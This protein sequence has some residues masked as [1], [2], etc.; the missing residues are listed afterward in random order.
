[1]SKRSVIVSKAFT[2]VE[3]LVVIVV[4]GI[5]AAIGIVAYN[6]IQNR[7][8]IDV[9][10][11]ELAQNYKQLATYAIVNSD[12]YPGTILAAQAAGVKNA[13]GTTIAYIP[14][15][16]TVPAATPQTFCLQETYGPS[17]Y[18]VSSVTSSAAAAG[19]CGSS[20]CPSGYIPVPGNS[21]FGTSDF[22]IMKYDAKNVSGIVV[23]QPSGVLWE[24][25]TQTNAISLAASSCA[26]CHIPTES[27]W[28]T[29]A[30]NVLSVST[31]WSGGSVG[32]GYIYS[33]HS[34]NNPNTDGLGSDT[35]DAN[36]YFGESSPTLDQK[37]TLTL[38]NGAVIWDFAGN[39]WQWTQGTV[40]GNQQPGL[41]GDAG[42]TV[43][44]WTDGSLVIRG[45]P[46]LS[47]PGSVSSQAGTWNSTQGVGKIDSYYGE[48]LLHGIT[49]GGSRNNTART[50][51][52]SVELAGDT[53]TSNWS[54]LGVRIVAAP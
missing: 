22:C 2:I 27:E 50:G 34:D 7:V 4:I 9:I 51:V 52:L 44:E 16:S 33:G 13:T 14:S 8:K 17:V 48:T 45:L 29:V 32:K 28:M 15:V 43:K 41:V 40:A 23:S 42:Y 47:L 37:R 35:N 54:T 21:T 49:R 5:L 30:A 6:G 3:L 38:T 25:I 24:S 39:M 10:Q 36:G 1:M 12:Q 19:T 26:T 46:L 18:Y 20:N 53:T 31:N 11:A